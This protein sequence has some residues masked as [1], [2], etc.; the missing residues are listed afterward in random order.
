MKSILHW[1][2]AAILIAAPAVN[3]QQPEDEQPGL[4]IRGL[5]FQLEKPLT[6]VFAHDPSSNEAGVKVA[7]KN[8]LNHEVDIV[9]VKGT[10][11][12]FTTK[13][14]PAS[15]KSAA[16]LVARVS[17]PANLKSGVFMFLP[18]SSRPGDPPNRVLVIEDQ[19]RVFPRGSLKILNLSPL[20]VRIQLEKQNF[21][22]RSG[23]TKVIEDPPV[24]ANNSSGMVA[25]AIRNNQPQRI[26]AQVWPHPGSKRVLQ[27]LFEN[28]RSGQVEMAGFRDIAVP[29]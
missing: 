8:Y 18:G 6:E 1:L 4:R 21:D 13:S 29:Y 23:E 9:P 10:S 24:G 11:L 19:M 28:P 17:L 25:W 14:D 2:S 15:A 26:G 20:P 7:V 22:F 3:A 5:A 12:V 16:D 27:V